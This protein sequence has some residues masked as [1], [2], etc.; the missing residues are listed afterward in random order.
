M[1]ATGRG[2]AL[3]ILYKDA[4]ALQKA[5]DSNCVLLDKT[6]TLTVGQ[7]KVTDFA[8]YQGDKTE[9]LALAA[10]I[11]RHSNH[12]IAECI[13]GYA[14]TE[15]PQ[16]IVDVSDF[17]YEMGKG[18]SVCYQG[19]T[20]RLGNRRLL[21]KGLDKQ[22]LQIEQNYSQQGKTAVFW[23]RMMLCLPCLLWR[24]R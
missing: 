2:M 1:A 14:E 10:A 12:P 15:A 6:A 22:A 20:Y 21:E 17:T 4:E 7:P 23:R 3:G 13:R 8:V 5:K 16:N 11:E 19:Q 9:C 24:I 18:A